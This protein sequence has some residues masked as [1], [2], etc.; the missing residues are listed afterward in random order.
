MGHWQAPWFLVLGQIPNPGPNSCVG[1]GV[2]RD[3]VSA[4]CCLFTGLRI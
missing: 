4:Q 2:G 3:G 1:Q